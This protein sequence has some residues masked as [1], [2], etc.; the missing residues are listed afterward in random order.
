MNLFYPAMEK[1][2]IYEL[3]MEKLVNYELILLCHGEVSYL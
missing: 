3:A 2:V 1:L